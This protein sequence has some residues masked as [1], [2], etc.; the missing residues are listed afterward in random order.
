MFSDSCIVQGELCSTLSRCFKGIVRKSA[1]SRYVFFS[2]LCVSRTSDTNN[3]RFLMKKQKGSV[4]SA[5]TKLAVLLIPRY[6]ETFVNW[7]L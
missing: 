2:F 1:T 6:P 4:Y 7:Q 3:N 5:L